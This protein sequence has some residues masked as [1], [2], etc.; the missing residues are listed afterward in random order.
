M[1]DVKAFVAAKESVEEALLKQPGVTGVGVGYKYVGGKRTD[2]V[3]VQVFVKEKKKTVPKGERI[4]QRIAGQLTDVIQRTFRPHTA[5]AKVLELRPMADTGTYNPVK[6]GIS[7]GPCRVIGGFVYTGTL[8]AIVRDNVT[9]DPLLLSN[10]HVMAVDSGWN[11]GD[12]MAQPS[13]VDTGSCPGSVVGTLLRAQLTSSVDAAVSTLQGRGHSC[14]IVGIGTVT[15]QASAALNVAVRK[16]GRTTGLSYG[17][18]DSVSLSVS[19][20]YGDGIGTRILTNQI[21]IDPDT[22]RNAL[23]GDHG[24]SGSVVVDDSR[25]V[26]GLYFAGSDDGYGVANP[27]AAVLSALNVSLCVGKSFI[28][29]LKDG[30]FEIKERKFEKREKWEIKERKLEKLEKFELKEAKPEKFEVEGGKTI[31]SEL[32]PKGPREGDPFVPPVIDPTQPIGPGAA[33]APGQLETFIGSELRP[34]LNAGALS[35]EPDYAEISRR[36]TKDA[37]DAL[38]TKAAFDNKI[39]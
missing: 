37:A 16:R 15:G 2:Q 34:D 32:D 27:I 21:G 17:T 24:D 1:E 8:G 19:I 26:L 4:P 22:T 12:T 7:I 36:L 33:F 30:K 23:F 18:V 14:E 5:S 20:D 3:A 29:E 31:V 38:Q 39:G 10:F 35:N 28:K 13:R 11:V 6:G 9:N 25:R